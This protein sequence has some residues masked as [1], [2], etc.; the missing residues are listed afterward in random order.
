M[1]KGG[2]RQAKYVKML[3]RKHITSTLYFFIINFYA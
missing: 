1:H 2:H 3:Y